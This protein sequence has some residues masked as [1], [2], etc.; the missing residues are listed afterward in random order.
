MK[1]DINKDGKVDIY[2]V[3]DFQQIKTG[4]PT[5][6]FQNR[7]DY[8]D[9]LKDAT[10]KIQP[11]VIQTDNGVVQVKTT[12]LNLMKAKTY[13]EGL[14]LQQD[15]SPTPQMLSVAKERGVDITKPENQQ[16]TLS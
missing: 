16:K 15:G 12:G 5:F 10:T 9:L 13:A 3:Q 8:E 14:F 2:D 7:Y 6:N 1:Q 11:E 4:L